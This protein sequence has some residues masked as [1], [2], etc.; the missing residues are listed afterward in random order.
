MSALI[1]QI[2]TAY[3]LNG[4]SPEQ[5]AENFDGVD[6]AS[7]KAALM[8][9]SAKYRKECNVEDNAEARVNFTDDQLEIVN[10]VIFE[11]ALAAEH[12]DGSVDYKT[13]LNAAMYIRD[14]KKGRKDVVK[15][16]QGNTFNFLQFNQQI[17]QAR[18]QAEELKKAICA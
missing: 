5:I 12:S 18:L 2:R 1:Q 17:Q 3:E 4:M 6:I 11:A 10:Q 15:Q 13:R 9:C 7:I 8:N 14:D 16:V